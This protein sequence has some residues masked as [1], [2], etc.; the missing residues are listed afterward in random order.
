SVRKNALVDV[1][2]RAR[3]TW[4]VDKSGE[5]VAEGLYNEVD[6]KPMTFMEWGRKLVTEAP[7][8]FEP[9]GG[10]GAGGGRSKRQE[11]ETTKVIDASDAYEFGKN[12]EGIAS[13][14]VKAINRNLGEFADT[15]NGEGD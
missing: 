1:K 6:G 9:G 3:Q 7:H 10:S 2:N 4:T 8:F 14:K 13:G 12:L 11:K 5:L 15:D